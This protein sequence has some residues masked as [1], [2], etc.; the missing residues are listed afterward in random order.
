MND[1]DRPDSR[2]FASDGRIESSKKQVAAFDGIQRM[3]YS[4]TME[5]GV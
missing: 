3:E 5:D 2:L 1:E 4:Q